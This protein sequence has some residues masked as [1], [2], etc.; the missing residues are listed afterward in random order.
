MKFLF[1]LAIFLFGLQ[2]VSGQDFVYKPK[3][4]PFGGYFQLSVVVSS[5]E[6]QNKFKDNYT[7][8]AQTE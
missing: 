5:A 4:I 7:S 3:R 2:L 6:S 8:P 1:I